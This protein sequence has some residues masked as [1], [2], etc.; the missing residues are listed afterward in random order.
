MSNE[1][2]QRFLALD[3]AEVSVV[4]TP[5]VEVEFLVVKRKQEQEMSQEAPQATAPATNAPV[6]VPTTTTVETTKATENA[7]SQV[8]ELVSQIA[9]AAG[10]QPVDE[11]VVEA[12]ADENVEKAKKGLGAVRK[13]YRTALKAS[14]VTGDAYKAAMKAFDD[15]HKTEE[16]TTTKAAEPAVDATTTA[17]GDLEMAISKAKMFTPERQLAMAQALATLKGVLEE[18]TSIPQGTNPKTNTPAMSTSPFTGV[19]VAK[20]LEDMTTVISKALE[21]QA[22]LLVDT[23]KRVETIEKTRQPG[24]A[25]TTEQTE[26]PVAK[27][28]SLWS[29]VF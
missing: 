1:A 22:K 27:K 28:A 13:S 23:A 26:K 29:G 11:E 15:S 12:A 24:N 5:A 9:K 8:I 21:D 14:N 16:T 25:L 7:M 2:K 19:A 17:L 4:D 10:V 20:A 3:V 6:L 18:M